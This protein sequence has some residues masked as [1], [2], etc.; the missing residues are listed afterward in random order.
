MRLAAGRTTEDAAPERR[1]LPVEAG[2]FPG[3]GPAV[4]YAHGGEFTYSEAQLTKY[5]AH[6]DWWHAHTL[7]P[8]N[9][10]DLIHSIFCAEGNNCFRIGTDPQGN[11]YIA[12]AGQEDHRRSPIPADSLT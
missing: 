1:V 10:R 8:E 7:S 4:L 5:R 9:S 3:A 6:M 12:I 11:A 2:A